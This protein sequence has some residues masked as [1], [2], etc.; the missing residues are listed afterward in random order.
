MDIQRL[1]EQIDLLSLVE[2]YTQVR[3]VASTNGGEWAGP[4][5]FCGGRDR[6]RLQPQHPAGG[7]WMC[8]VCTSGKWQDAITFGQRLWPGLRFRQVC[9]QLAEGRLPERPGEAVPAPMSAKPAYVPP[10]EAWQAAAR[11]A[12]QICQEQL[13][14]PR[15]TPALDYLRRRGLKDETIRSWSLGY[16]PGVKFD[17]GGRKDH[18]LYVARGVV[19]PCLAMGQVWYLKVCLLPDQKVRCQGCGEMCVARQPCPHCALVNKYR[20]VKGNRPAAIFGAD[21]LPG[22]P[23][24]LFV[25]G[26]FDAL[27][28]WQELRDVI[29][30]CTLGSATNRPDLLIWGPYLVPLQMILTT[31]DT[32]AAGQ[33]GLQALMAL[34]ERVYPCPLPPATEKAGDQ[35][36]GRVK[37]INDF[38][39]AGGQLW[40]WLKGHLQR[41]GVVGD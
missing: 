24:A 40:P 21:D 9:E 14:Q 38:Y 17:H 37:D 10:G 30:V 33:S 20:G 4:C 28:A 18:S 12:I 7:R 5:P 11:R 3:R 8:R 41:L 15:G 19:I 22:S 32:D 39:L 2:Q 13:W 34:S 36:G 26:E 27:I 31:Y 16:S 23:L 25:E 35:P 29:A 6:F 1:K